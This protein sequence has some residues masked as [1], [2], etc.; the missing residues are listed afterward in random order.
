MSAPKTLSDNFTRRVLI[1]IGLVT[2]VV[3]FLLLTWQMLDILVLFFASILLGVFLTGI[4]GWLRQHTSL[5]HRQALGLTLVGILLITGVGGWLA[6]PNLAEQGQQLGQDLQTSWETVSAQLESQSWAQPLL[7]NL[8][9][10]EQLGSSASTILSRGASFFSRTF[11]FFAN[12]VIILFVGFYL[13][14]EPDKYANGLIKL[15]PKSRRQRAGEVL[16]EAAYTLRWW[17]I[18]RL[19]SMAIVGALSLIGLLVLGIPLAFIL[20]IVTALL[21]FIP[22]IGPMLALVPPVL[23]AFT[24]SPQQALYVFLLYIGI[25]FLETYLITPIIQR[26]TVA[27][28]PVILIMSQVIMGLFLGF[29]GVAVAAPLAALLIVVTKM[30]YVNDVLGDSSPKLLK[31]NPEAHFAASQETTSPLPREA[32]TI[33]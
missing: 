21:T 2:A 15:L 14:F 10:P 22:I 9:N 24:M 4:S 20:S 30:L 16:D 28:P 29:L 6:A 32:V 12:F 31:E 5:S 27:L 13:A 33:E 3:L 18:G 11:G 19:S 23:I 1:V 25:Q 8:P 17:L 26:K 7:N